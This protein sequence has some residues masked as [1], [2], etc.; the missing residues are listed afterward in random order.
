MVVAGDFS[1]EPQMDAGDGGV[2]ELVEVRGQL[3]SGGVLGQ[4]GEEGRHGFEGEGKDDGVGCDGAGLIL[5]ADGG[6]PGF[7][8]W[9]WGDGFDAGAEGDFA[10]AFAEIAGGRAVEV[11][12]G[13]GGD[14]HAAGLG[15]E[16]EGFAKDFGGVVD[17]DAVEVFVEGGDEDG[18]PEAGY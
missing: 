2:F 17:G 10:A 6:E 7:A 4:G 8:G 18:F 11:A 16:Q 15:R 13:N 3:L 12:E 1:V 9:G 14:A 5:F